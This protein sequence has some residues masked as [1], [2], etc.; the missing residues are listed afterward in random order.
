MYIDH[1]T[2]IAPQLTPD[3]DNATSKLQLAKSPQAARKSSELVLITS[4]EFRGEVFVSMM[5]QLGFKRD[6]ASA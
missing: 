3:R 6:D 5:F 2:S 1:A 4:G